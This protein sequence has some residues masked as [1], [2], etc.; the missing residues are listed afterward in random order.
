[1]NIANPLAHGVLGASALGLLGTPSG[2]RIRTES[3]RARRRALKRFDTRG[4]RP[5]RGGRLVE[6]VLTAPNASPRCA[7]PHRLSGARTPRAVVSNT[8]TAAAYGRTAPCEIGAHPRTAAPVQRR[9]RGQRHTHP[10]R[11][12]PLE[13]IAD[14]AADIDTYSVDGFLLIHLSLYTSMLPSLSLHQCWKL[15]VHPQSYRKRISLNSGSSALRVRPVLCN[16]LHVSPEAILHMPRQHLARREVGRER[17]EV[18]GHGIK[19]SALIGHNSS[20]V[21]RILRENGC[22]S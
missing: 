14:G 3:P 20:R 11:R 1:M 21:G 17:Y 18:A 12:R 5:T 8:G 10:N 2:Q 22:Q 7:A 9:R 6:R 19:R 16:F 4:E 15:T 13:R